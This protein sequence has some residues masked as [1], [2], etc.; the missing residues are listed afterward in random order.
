MSA[1]LASLDQKRTGLTPGTMSLGVP[2][3]CGCAR[4]TRTRG[5]IRVASSPAICSGS[6]RRPIASW[7]GSPGRRR[8]DRGRARRGLGGAQVHD[9]GEHRADRSRQRQG[10]PADRPGECRRGRSGRSDAVGD[11]GR[12]HGRAARRCHRA[13]RPALAAAGPLRGRR[14]GPRLAPVRDGVW[15]LSTVKAEIVRIAGGRVVLRTPVDRS[16]RPLLAAGMMPPIAAG[17]ALGHHNRVIRLDPDSGRATA[18]I[19]V[20]DHRPTALVAA[21]DPRTSSPRTAGLRSSARDKRAS[22]DPEPVGGTGS[23]SGVGVSMR[24]RDAWSVSEARLLTDFP[25][26]GLLCCAALSVREDRVRFAV[27]GRRSRG[28]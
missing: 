1:R 22:E 25:R 26:L 12:R 28:G 6:A 18:A 23:G 4:R 21:G 24:A 15:V 17:D 13:H 10:D 8:R 2:P 7:H 20:G 9:A 19:E 27:G 14:L 3:A 11:P 16:V 5:R